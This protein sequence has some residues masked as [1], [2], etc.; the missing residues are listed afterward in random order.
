MAL[1]LTS[2]RTGAHDYAVVSDRGQAL[3]RTWATHIA[4]SAADKIAITRPGATQ[5]AVGNAVHG[6]IA[7]A[8]AVAVVSLALDVPA[9]PGPFARA[10]AA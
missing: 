2:T 5:I 9:C 6:A 10:T 7:R 3:P 8:R 4:S 1:D